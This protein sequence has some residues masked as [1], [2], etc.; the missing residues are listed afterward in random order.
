MTTEM[1]VETK[2]FQHT[3]HTYCHLYS[4]LHLLRVVTRMAPS[5]R[6]LQ[7]VQGGR[8]LGQIPVTGFCE[9][10]NEPFICLFSGFICFSYGP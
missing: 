6:A 2:Q 9:L 10:G 8:H 7:R 4:R 1:Q 5:V 3:R